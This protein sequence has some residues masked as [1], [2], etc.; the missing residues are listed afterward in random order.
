MHVSNRSL[1]V[2]QLQSHSESHVCILFLISQ[3]PLSSSWLEGNFIT[4]ILESCVWIYLL[5]KTVCH[6]CFPEPSLLPLSLEYNQFLSYSPGPKIDSQFRKPQSSV[7]TILRH[8]SRLVWKTASEIMELDWWQ[9][10]HIHGQLDSQ[11]SSTTGSSNP[12]GMEDHSDHVW[13]RNIVRSQVLQNHSTY[14]AWSRRKGF[15]GFNPLTIPI[16]LLTRHGASEYG[17]RLLSEGRFMG[18]VTTRSIA[19]SVLGAQIL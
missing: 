3:M 13:W 7:F 4:A 17:L 12:T 15:V 11:R 9:L 5:W 2:V 16:G 10:G 8:V 1:A 18:I 19:E 6:C 14:T